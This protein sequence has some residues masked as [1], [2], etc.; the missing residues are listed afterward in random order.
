MSHLTASKNAVNVIC[1]VFR[2]NDHILL[3]I[4]SRRTSSIGL[5]NML[6]ALL[7]ANGSRQNSYL[8][9]L[10]NNEV[11]F[12]SKYEC[13]DLFSVCL[14]GILVDLSSQLSWFLLCCLMSSW[15]LID[16]CVRFTCHTLHSLSCIF[17]VVLRFCQV[18]FF[19]FFFT[20]CY[21]LSSNSLSNYVPLL[22]L[23]YPILA[24]CQGFSPAQLV[25]K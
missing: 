25:D 21:S 23:Y 24:F 6:P 19:L 3:P 5:W 11:F 20:Q 7:S 15:G 14:L 4:C 9:L 12:Q 13:S 18:V 10:T 2:E 16:L 17:Y 22:H 1:L 8:P